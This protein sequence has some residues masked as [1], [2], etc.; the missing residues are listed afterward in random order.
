MT[1]TDR[2]CGIGKNDLGRR[3]MSSSRGRFGRGG[4]QFRRVAVNIDDY[5]VY[6]KDYLEKIV[7]SEPITESEKDLV[8]FHRDLVNF[9][10]SPGEPN[11][12]VPLQRSDYEEGVLKAR[13]VQQ[14]GAESFPDEL[15]ERKI[16]GV[17]PL[18]SLRKQALKQSMKNLEDAEGRGGEEEEEGGEEDADNISDSEVSNADYEITGDFEDGGADDFGDGGGGDGDGDVI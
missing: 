17:R 7:S 3:R 13:L 12:R 15:V 11:Y 2:Q 18:L 8:D 14:L 4:R 6:P 10:V 16:A 5:S 1:A 9:Y